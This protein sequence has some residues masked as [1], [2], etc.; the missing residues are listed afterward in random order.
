MNLIKLNNSCRIKLVK[1]QHKIKLFSSSDD[2]T[3]N[4]IE[5]KVQLLKSTYC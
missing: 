1:S 4:K 2:S 3:N 5:E